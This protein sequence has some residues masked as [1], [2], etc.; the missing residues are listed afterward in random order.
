MQHIVLRYCAIHV[1]HTCIVLTK[2]IKLT[3][4]PIFFLQWTVFRLEILAMIISNG[5]YILIFEQIPSKYI[6]SI[7]RNWKNRTYLAESLL[8]LEYFNV[9]AT[10]WYLSSPQRP[11]S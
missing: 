5:Q 8:Q 6:K 10:I 9:N 11:P 2:V 4:N 1:Q 7:E 3:R